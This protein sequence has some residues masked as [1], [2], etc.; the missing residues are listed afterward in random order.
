M[1]A[2]R[3]MFIARNVSNELWAEAIG[4]AVFVQNRTLSSTGHATPYEIVYGEKPD[5]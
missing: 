1:E 4:Y 5:V 3:T 2:A